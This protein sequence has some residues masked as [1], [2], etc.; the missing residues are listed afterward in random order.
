VVDDI[1]KF[2][3]IALAQA[4]GPAEPRVISAFLDPRA[5]PG[6]LPCI[7]TASQYNKRL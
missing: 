1:A 4:V 6:L 5:R 2:M 3:E 7:H